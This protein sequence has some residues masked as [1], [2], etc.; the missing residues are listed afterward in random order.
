MFYRGPTHRQHRHIAK[1]SRK[2]TRAISVF[3]GSGFHLFCLQ[4]HFGT[5]I[6]FCFAGARNKV[7]WAEPAKPNVPSSS[8]F[9]GLHFKQP[10]LRELPLMFRKQ[11]LHP[12]G[13]FSDNG[14]QVMTEITAAPG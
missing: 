9:V 11:A 5:S 13:L 10:C 7:G 1:S 14:R 2:E 8:H 4:F 6:T 3:P 12:Q